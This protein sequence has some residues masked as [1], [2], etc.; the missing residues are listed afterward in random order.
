MTHIE[1]RNNSV[2]LFHS[3][4]CLFLLFLTDLFVNSKEDWDE[5]YVSRS[6]GPPLVKHGSI[7]IFLKSNISSKTTK[8]P[9][10]STV[11][12]T[13]FFLVNAFKLFMR[14]GF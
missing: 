9:L 11:S 4:R 6:L 13:N 3:F 2:T 14:S 1:A 10:S 7:F 8:P 12:E 5:K